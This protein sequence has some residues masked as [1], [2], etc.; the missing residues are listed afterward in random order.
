MNQEQIILRTTE[1]ETSS[2]IPFEKIQAIFEM[3]KNSDEMKE[4]QKVRQKSQINFDINFD[5]DKM[6]GLDNFN[7]LNENEPA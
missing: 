5:I 7:S 3:Y 6:R 1:R 2:E 4:L